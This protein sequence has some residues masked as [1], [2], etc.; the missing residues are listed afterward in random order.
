[1]LVIGAAALIAACAIRVWLYV[2]IDFDRVATPL[3]ED[4]F[5]TTFSDLLWIHLYRAR[6]RI[7]P[8]YKPRIIA[9]FWLTVAATVLLSVGSVTHW[10]TA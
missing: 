3:L 10:L 4:T 8:R 6:D 1:M 9:Y 5:V 2:A 7:D